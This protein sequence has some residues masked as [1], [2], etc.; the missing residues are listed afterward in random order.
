MSKMRVAML[1]LAA[2]SAVGAGILAKGF[3]S[4]N[5]NKP[6][7][8]V[9]KIAKEEVLVIS[10]DVL[11]GDKLGDGVVVWQDWPSKQVQ[12]SMITKSSR[13]TALEDF[14]DA[15]SRYAM[16]QGE[17]V[18]EKKVVLPGDKGFMSAILPK[19]MRA[20]SVAVSARTTAGG[21]ILPNDRVDV[22]LTR[23]IDRVESQ[24]KDVKSETVLSNV[25]VLAI[26]QTYRAEADGT[27]AS[28][29]AGETATLELT[30]E[31][32]EVITR[33]ESTGE[34]ALALRSIAE[35]EGNAI[36]SDKPVL[37]AG[38]AKGAGNDGPG[39]LEK[40]LATQAAPAP[41]TS[42]KSITFIKSGV[43]SVQ[44]NR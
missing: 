43:Q 24:E 11:M 32:S 31:Q 41:T 42:G 3:L 25:R 4:R 27:A 16:Y 10:R 34:L 30:P 6:M 15:R 12:P 28:V 20:I 9:E 18:V 2:V 35:S 17:T 44:T 21:F 8:A 26:N 29:P 5:S 7:V 14:K 13:P 37:A 19:G 39:F 40:L 33:I 1:A 36:G 23:K 38:Y 22:I